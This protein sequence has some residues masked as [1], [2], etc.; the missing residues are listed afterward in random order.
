MKRA[1]ILAAGLGSRFKELTK[2]S[3]KA[4]FPVNGV[5]NLLRT[6]RFL[7]EADITGISVVTG[8]N[9]HLLRPI[10]EEEGCTEFF[11]PHYKTYNNMY[12]LWCA[13]EKLDT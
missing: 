3:H 8:H 10:L 2:T 5:P 12:S 13:R 7:K 11:N 4:L 1:I 6:I 9:A